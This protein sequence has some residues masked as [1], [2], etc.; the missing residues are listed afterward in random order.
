VKK[1]DL[2][3]RQIL[4]F[5]GKGGVGKTTTAAMFAALSADQGARTL[6][7]STDPAHSTAD[8]LGT[9]IG[10]EP[11][12][13]TENLSAI[14]IDPEKAADEYI[15]GVKA[16]IADATPP[17]LAQEVE[18]QIDIARVSPGAEDAALFDRFAG[19]M[20]EERFRFDR[21]I[22]DTA[23]T[24]HTIRLM[25]LPETMADW[26]SG[27]IGQRKKVNVINK[28]WRNGAGAAAGSES[29]P[30]DP[31]LDA[32]EARKERFSRARA[33]IINRER[34]AFVFVLTPER[35]PILET[36]R[37]IDTLERYQVPIGGVIV[38]RILP[39]MTDSAFMARRYERQSGYLEE[40]DSLF[41]HRI[42]HRIPLQQEDVLGVDSLLAVGR[43][44]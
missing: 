25:T 13:I 16:R 42:L 30:N 33:T 19:I 3:D 24:G 11:T 18:R 27:L 31:I 32:L 38:N 37:A 28:M 26:I 5:G 22:F 43:A 35:L 29:E 6:L 14:E 9:S 7:V 34:S 20:D 44:L 39:E 2:L 1:R 36:K 40:I 12:E 8:I 10:A 17:R 21:I 15:E 23:P 41:A 4:F